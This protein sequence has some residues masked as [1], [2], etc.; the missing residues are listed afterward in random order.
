MILMENK[1]S[2]WR[3]LHLSLHHWK[4]QQSQSRNK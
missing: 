1:Q 4:G 3:L 2:Q